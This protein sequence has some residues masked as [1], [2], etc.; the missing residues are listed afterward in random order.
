MADP[1]TWAAIGLTVAG[2]AVTAYG[3]YSSGQAQDKAYQYKAG[4]A[5]LN[6]QVAK[7][8]ADYY[9]KAGEVEA[10]KSGFASRWREGNIKAGQGASNIDVNSGTS[11]MVQDSQKEIGRWDQATIRSNAAR[12]AYGAEVE[13]INY[14]AQ[15]NI[16]RMAGANAARAGGISAVGTLLGTAGSVAGKWT[17]ASGAFGSAYDPNAGWVLD[18]DGLPVG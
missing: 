17:Q 15:A 13:G 7:Q 8:N 12:R 16:D 18:A 6:Q 5:Q 1:F 10:E 14:S 11:S 9:R 3:Q 4:V 2:G